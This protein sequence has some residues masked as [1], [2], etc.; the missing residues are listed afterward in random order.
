LKARGE[1]AATAWKSSGISPIGWRPSFEIQ[2]G[3]L[4]ITLKTQR[5]GNLKDDIVI[6]SNTVGS[7]ARQGRWLPQW[8]AFV[9]C[10]PD[11]PE[12]VQLL[13]FW[14]AVQSWREKGYGY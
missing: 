4:S 1:I 13:C 2:A 14:L 9:E 11:V 12:L 3:A 5:L 8:P 6:S 7:I 10:P